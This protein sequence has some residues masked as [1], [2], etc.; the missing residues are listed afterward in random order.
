MGELL[1]KK[2]GWKPGQG[3]GKNQDGSLT[4]LLLDVK[5]DK[6]GLV[7]EDE[8]PGGKR[9]A[10]VTLT[11]MKDVSGESWGR[12]GASSGTEARFCGMRSPS[13]SETG[14]CNSRM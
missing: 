11:N 3:L 6:K 14:I 12:R 4:P 2:M 8:R 5:M 10:P 13:V 1:L 7:S 9:Q